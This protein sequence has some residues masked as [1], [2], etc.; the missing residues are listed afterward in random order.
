MP[1]LIRQKLDV[2]EPHGK[3]LRVYTD[4]F[5]SQVVR[6]SHLLT[7]ENNDSENL[8]SVRP[9]I[10]KINYKTTEMLEGMLWFREYSA[11]NHATDPLVIPEAKSVGKG[12]RRDP[13]YVNEALKKK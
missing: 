11:G 5:D 10:V 2:L 8:D 9:I 13:N 12:S 3:R 1:L 7:K 4:L 6:L